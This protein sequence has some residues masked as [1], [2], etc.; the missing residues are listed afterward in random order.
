MDL[1]GG[2]EP[3][4]LIITAGGGAR[5]TPGWL[6]GTSCT[7]GEALLVAFEV[8]KEEWELA[9]WSRGKGVL[10]EDTARA[11]LGSGLRRT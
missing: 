3:G 7:S 2:G 6:G 1:E 9:K 4:R 11:K 8:L 5:A 10:G